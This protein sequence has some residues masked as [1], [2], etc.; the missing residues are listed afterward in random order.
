MQADAWLWV[1][2]LYYSFLG[3]EFSGVVDKTE[4]Y[5]EA[6]IFFCVS[7]GSMSFLRLSLVLD[8]CGIYWHE[9]FH[10]AW[11]S[12][13]PFTSLPQLSLSQR[14]SPGGADMS[15]FIFLEVPTSSHFLD[16]TSHQL[17]SSTAW[18]FSAHICTPFCGL[19]VFL[20]ALRA[21]DS[22]NR[23]LGTPKPL[24]CLGNLH[25]S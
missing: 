8:A 25:P 3:I 2:P 11:F 1:L 4:T 18:T 6:D 7:G 15:P 9:R 16:W 22:W 13:G 14:C 5:G 24:N 20:Y 21:V 23:C 10:C 17:V 19:D 12:L